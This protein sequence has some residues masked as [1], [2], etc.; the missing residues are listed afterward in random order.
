MTELEF[1][2]SKKA[3]HTIPAEDKGDF[4]NEKHFSWSVKTQ[5][6]SFAESEKI[7]NLIAEQAGEL[8]GII[9]QLLNSAVLEVKLTIHFSKNTKKNSYSLS[10]YIVDYSKQPNI[11]MI[12]QM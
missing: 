8:A 4:E 12:T 3:L 6:L 9:Q 10:T 5:P 11:G 7:F 1:E 2:W